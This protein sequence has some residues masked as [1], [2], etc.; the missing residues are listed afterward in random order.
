VTV[1][2]L[3]LK[4]H[5]ERDGYH[6]ERFD[7]YLGDALICTSRSGWHDPARELLKRGYSP[8]TPLHVQHVGRA[9]DSTIVPQ[10][11]GELAK[12]TIKERDRGG[13]SR[14]R[15]CPYPDREPAGS[16]PVEA[17]AGAERVSGTSDAIGGR[18]MSS[19]RHDRDF[20]LADVRPISIRDADGELVQP[21]QQRELHLRRVM[22][23]Q[24]VLRSARI[25][26][27]RGY[28]TV[29]QPAAPSPRT[30]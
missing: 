24:R 13:L 21:Y 23:Y 18:G 26:G 1:L 20:K 25:D 12:W 5:I 9:F 8:D 22:D 4:P 16:S 29:G 15:W 28:N 14:E 30:P 19:R 6:T 3:T 11:I 10:P 2:A 7:A 27:P 17:P